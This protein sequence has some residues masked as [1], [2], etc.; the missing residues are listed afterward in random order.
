MDFGRDA[1][2]LLGREPKVSTIWTDAAALELLPLRAL[3][4][5]AAAAGL[6]AH[7]ADRR[8]RA[9]KLLVYAAMLRE[10]A[11]RT[12]DAD[13]LA[14]AASAAARAGSES[15]GEGLAAARLEQ[16]ASARLGAELF[17]D[18][19]AA[20]GARRLLDEADAATSSKL[21]PEL[22][23]R[24]TALSAAL[25]AGA[26]LADA[27]LDQAI[28]AA[29]VLDT[30][31]DRLDAEVRAT[32]K[33]Q[34]E[35]AGLACDRADVLIGFGTRLKDRA[36]LGRAERDLA[37]LSRRLDPDYLPLS[38]ARSEG[39]RGAALAALGDLDGDAASLTSSVTIL[40]AAAENADFD[41]SP[42][43][44]ARIS[45]TLGL[46]LAALAE[47]SDDEGLFD[48]A[49]AALDQALAALPDGEG[50]TL[51]AVA[52]HDRA[53]CVA[54]RAERSGDAKAL[55]RAESLFRAELSVRD[56]AADPTA[57]AVTQLALTRIYVAQAALPGG[58]APPASAS[59]AL[60]EAL[61][62]FV[63]RGLKSLAEIAQ[64][65]LE[66]LR[67]IEGR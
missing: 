5:Q 33:G 2:R 31:V 23:L 61:D 67:E 11:R 32:G 42:F 66:Q 49:L 19:A 18:A 58:A 52:S 60:T 64:T 30:A 1:R 62:V 63:E 27:D 43:D 14:K 12:G 10:I 48:H 6:A 50:L 53:A 55:A 16:A 13:T 26:A 45:H 29:D 3:K 15:Q 21:R 36:L 35:A 40:A 56:A 51:R 41:H 37:D 39:L 4:G 54:R 65:A 59:V 38:W 17:A 20:Q 24:R 25:A 8:E 44:R 7:Q 9:P 22:A 47:A 57:W 46:A 34:A 28:E